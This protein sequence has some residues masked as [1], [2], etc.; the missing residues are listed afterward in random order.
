[1]NYFTLRNSKGPSW[2]DVKLVNLRREFSKLRLTWCRTYSAESC[3]PW[4]EA[5][6]G[7]RAGGA[8]RRV[9]RAAKGTLLQRLPPVLSVLANTHEDLRIRLRLKRVQDEN[10]VIARPTWE[11]V[12]AFWVQHADRMPQLLSA[13]EY[14]ATS[15]AH[16]LERQ[17][18]C[19]PFFNC[20]PQVLADAGCVELLLSHPGWLE[21]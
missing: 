12:S 1:M 17:T 7:Q 10:S 3:E 18:L 13:A 21:A 8:C 5:Q 15:S 14:A 4:P 19:S 9:A 2:V 6:A 20:L 16:A 11:T